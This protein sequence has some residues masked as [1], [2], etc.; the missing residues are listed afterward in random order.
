MSLC[1]LLWYLC[2]ALQQAVEHEAA[3]QRPDGQ[4]VREADG[5]VGDDGAPA[6]YLPF[7]RIKAEVEEFEKDPEGKMLEMARG[8]E[9]G[10]AGVLEGIEESGDSVHYRVRGDT[11]DL[12][13]VNQDPRAAE[14]ELP[15]MEIDIMQHAT[16]VR[17]AGPIGAESV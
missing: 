5:G 10:Q 11:A 3:Q 17:G 14:N 2:P 1:P 9:E 4:R 13:V 15:T 6:Q 8:L 16:P 7:A 12:I